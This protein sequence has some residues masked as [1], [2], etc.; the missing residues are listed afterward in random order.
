MQQALEDHTFNIIGLDA[1]QQQQADNQD[2]L[3]CKEMCHP[4]F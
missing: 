2:I 4:L 3:L 1:L